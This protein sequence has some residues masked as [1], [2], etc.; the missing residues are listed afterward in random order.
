[1]IVD[2][3]PL[4]SNDFLMRGSH[5][6]TLGTLICRICGSNKWIVGKASYFTAVKCSNCDYECCVHDG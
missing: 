6:K 4:D 5:C 3:P 2:I 1:M